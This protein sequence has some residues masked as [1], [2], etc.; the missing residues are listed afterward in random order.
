[1]DYG[2]VELAMHKSHIRINAKQSQFKGSTR[3]VRSHIIKHCL[4]MGQA[5][6]DDLYHA[7]AQ[8][9][10]YDRVQ[11]DEIIHKMIKD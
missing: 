3:R 11:F 4:K 7:Y 9:W 8:P 5:I 2:A 10:D 1:M 6:V